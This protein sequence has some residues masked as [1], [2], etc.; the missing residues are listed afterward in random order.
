MRLIAFA[1]RKPVSIVMIS[2]GAV[3][4]GLLSLWHLPLDLFP[5]VD[6]PVVTINTRLSGYSPV[7]I[8]ALVTK[9]L[10]EV[11]STVNNV[12]SVQSLSKEGESEIRVE[13]KLG[14]NMDFAS[15]LL[16][17]RIDLIKGDFPR[18]TQPPI[19]SKRN[20]AS[21]PILLLTAFGEAGPARL[22]EIAD[23]VIKKRLERIPGV[24]NVEVAGGKEREIVVDVEEGALKGLGISVMDIA[25]VIKK[26]NQNLPVGSV[27]RGSSELAARTIGEVHSLKE[28][29]EIPL[30]QT[31]RSSLVRVKDVGQVKDDFRESETIALFKGEPRV[32]ITIQKESEANTLRIADAVEKEIR[33]LRPNL[34]PGVK[35]E[36]FFS[37][38]DYIRSSLKR[39]KGAIFLGGALAM[40]VLFVFL[41]HLPSTLIIGISIPLSVIST[42]SFMFFMGIT[43][44]VI[45][46]SGLALG[47]GMIVDNSIVVLENIFRQQRRGSSPPEAALLGGGEVITAIAASTLAHIAVFFPLVFVQKKVQMLYSGLFYTVSFSLLVSLGVAITIV[48]MLSAWVPSGPKRE[49]AL[50]RRSLRIYRKVLLVALR[51]RKVVAVAFLILFG[52]SLYL[53]KFIGFEATGAMER[54]EFR[55]RVQ[56]PPG[57]RSSVVQRVTGEIESILYEIPE[58]SDVSTEV[59]G[60]WA[61]LFV[62]LKKEGER[63][64]TREIVEMIRPKVRL[65]PRAQ[66]TFS[67]DRVTGKGHSIAIQVNGFDQKKLLS[68][69]VQIRRKLLDVKGVSDVLVRQANEKPEI[70]VRVLHDKAGAMHL[71]ATSIAH[72]IRAAFTGPISTTYR[73]RGKEIDLRVRIRPEGRRDARSLP[74]L[75][76]IEPVNRTPIPL[77][78][79]CQFEEGYGPG[80]IHRKDQQR[81]IEVQAEISEDIDIQKAAS[82]IEQ[83]LSSL[84]FENGYGY[85]FGEDYQELKASQ[86][87]LLFAVILAVVL[88]YM[89]L[90]SLFESLL[91]P[92]AIML[93]VPLAAMGVLWMFFATGKPMNVGVYVGVIAL[94]GIVVNNAIVLVD[95]IKLMRERGMGRW[96]AILVAGEMRLRPILMTSATT[97]LG[98]LPMALDRSLEAALW[99]PLAL[100]IISGLSVSTVLT[101]IVVPVAYSLL[102]DLRR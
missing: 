38:A 86:K 49:G 93:S 31:S 10:E 18:D 64:A 101:L 73:E 98:L 94:A 75:L 91:H 60:D 32:S 27:G 51:Y 47:I 54:G 80:E 66:V 2:V 53:I 22:R 20:P 42:F 84:R 8:E 34:P 40:G 30:V 70:Q 61:K 50:R 13:F 65:I 82:L 58:V 45:S 100:A 5:D 7:H 46:M 48:P 74:Y 83:E 39:L 9:P 59:K 36:V 52:V 11:V 89:I 6:F 28:V 12:K 17:E 67:I 97:V 56:T 43:L 69:A 79:V 29:E 19:I 33:G 81:M 71:S 92:F 77:I 16:R 68:Y 15:L 76:A 35:L 102:E 78:E 21:N 23:D 57:T 3:I 1:I 14:T 95:F 72:T 63:R 26:S 24:A 41:R 87:E 62:R 55:I 88:V 85:A 25:N 90:A 44:N 96:R 99:S 37:Q 4:L